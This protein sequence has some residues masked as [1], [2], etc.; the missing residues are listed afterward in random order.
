MRD[1]LR[2]ARWL[3]REAGARALHHYR[4]PFSYE[5][6]P[7]GQGLVTEADRALNSFIVEAI[8]ASFP[9]DAILAEESE[10]DRQRLGA[11][12]VWT[13][14]PI[15]GTREFVAR[16][17]EFSVMLGLLVEGRPAL[18][19]IFQPTTGRLFLGAKGEGAFLE[20][21]G[22][23]PRR[24]RV[25]ET[26][27]SALRMA[28][29]KPW[30]GRRVELIRQELGIAQILPMGSVSLKLAMI[31]AG[32]ADLYVNPSGHLAEWDTCAGEL[33]LDEAGGMISDL[34]GRP[35]IYNRQ[36]VCHTGGVLA[37]HGR[38]HPDLLRGIA[39]LRARLSQEALSTPTRVNPALK[40]EEP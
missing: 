18:G 28:V 26:P 32:E 39:V 6:K 40:P 4:R 16:S 1:E 12:R 23:A 20:E 22:A 19:A 2:F 33:I 36:E 25:S 13:V 35:L 27:F 7:G 34:E 29:A 17:G 9:K 10:D 15:D 30:R 38:C 5:E 31:A 11:R 21:E 24:L 3:V 14:D 37:S 8:G